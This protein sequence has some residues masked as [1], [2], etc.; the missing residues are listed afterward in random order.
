MSETALNA[1]P[2]AAINARAPPMY[3]TA[4]PVTADWSS[5]MLSTSHQPLSPH[6]GHYKRF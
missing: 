6:A 3:L 4:I 5:P 2:S 1:N